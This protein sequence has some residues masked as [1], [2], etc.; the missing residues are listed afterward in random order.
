MDKKVE[1]RYI[2]RIKNECH[3]GD[4]EKDGVV[5][6][7]ILCD[8]LCELGFLDVVSEYNDVYRY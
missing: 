6:D 4:P 1:G 2:E 8:L 5:A 3:S 7:R